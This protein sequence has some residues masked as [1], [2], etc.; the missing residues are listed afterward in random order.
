MPPWPSHAAPTKS[1]SFRITSHESRTQLDMAVQRDPDV[2]PVRVLRR[3]VEHDISKRMSS[4]NAPCRFQQK[5][6]LSSANATGPGCCRIPQANNCLDSSPIAFPCHEMDAY[7]LANSGRT[8]VVP[9]LEHR[10]NRQMNRQGQRRSRHLYLLHHLLNLLHVF[11][12]TL[13][14]LLSRYQLRVT[15]ST[16]KEMAASNF[17]LAKQIKRVK[18]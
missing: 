17:S 13:V 8:D 5:V 16:S 7:Q 15:S 18:K 12:D 1:G 3:I 11:T 14:V 10:S 2:T 9:F 6:G 4:P